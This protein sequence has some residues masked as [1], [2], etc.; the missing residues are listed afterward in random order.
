MSQN[1]LVHTKN[2][3]DIERYERLGELAREMFAAIGDVPVNKIEEFF[4][5]DRGYCTPKVDLRAGVFEDDRILLVHEKSDNRWS[6]P[7]GW[8]DVNDTPSQGV[9][10]EIVEESGYIVDEV[11]LVAVIDRSAHPYKPRYPHHVYKLF[12]YGLPT[13][14]TEISH[15]HETADARFFGLDE[16]PELSEARVLRQD[17]DRLFE[18]HRNKQHVYVD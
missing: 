7:G 4:V 16:L 17:I 12:F 9:R 2:P 8:A 15:L 18:Y 5:P 11:E 3:F 1:G 14:R 10:R 6:M 13:G